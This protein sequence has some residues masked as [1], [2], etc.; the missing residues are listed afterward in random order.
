MIVEIR[1]VGFVNK[2]AELMLHAVLQKVKSKY[3]DVKFVMAPSLNVSPYEKR[4]SLGLLQKVTY[5]KAGLDIGD[6]FVSLIPKKRRK[7]YGLVRSKDVDIVLDASGFAHGDQW[8]VKNTNKLLKLTEKWKKNNSKIILL[9]Q[10]F[11][12]FKNE[13]IK[14]SMRGL[15]ENCDLIFAREEI[16]YEYLT[17]IVNEKKKIY[18]SPDFTNL[19]KASKIVDFDFENNDFCIIPNYKMVSKSW[20]ENEDNKYLSLIEESIKYLRLKGKKP[21]ILVHEGKKDFDLANEISKRVEGINIFKEE[22]P[23]KVK[24]ILNQSSGVIGSRFHSLVSAL[25]QATPALGTSWSHKYQMLFKDYDFEDGILNL[26]SSSE[27]IHKKIDILINEDS[28][29]KLIS[30]LEE[31]SSYLKEES[32]KMWEKVFEIFESKG[33][34]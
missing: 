23:L 29:N 30:K 19:V 8:G 12:P 10:A 17:S 25:S 13:E 2:G 22:D 5:E 18:N 11:G 1:G 27:D 33:K 6:F 28:K 7:M 4:A 14:N 24:G 15:V 26:D 9:P 32:E 31:R 20:I 16:S 3:P 21:F 34:N